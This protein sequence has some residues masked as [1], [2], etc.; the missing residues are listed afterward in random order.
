MSHI[1]SGGGVDD[2]DSVGADWIRGLGGSGRRAVNRR[3]SASI[4]A[5]RLRRRCSSASRLASLLS[6]VDFVVLKAR[7][8][9]ERTAVASDPSRI[10]VVVS[11]LDSDRT[12]RFN[13]SISPGIVGGNLYTFFEMRKYGMKVYSVYRSGSTAMIKIRQVEHRLLFSSP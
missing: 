7:L 5:R 12:T 4:L 9:L 1:D 8:L 13:V 2:L 11:R 6:T 3:F 10:C